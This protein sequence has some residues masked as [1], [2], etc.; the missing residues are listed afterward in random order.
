MRHE[1]ITFEVVKFRRSVVG[2]CPRCNARVVRTRTFEQ[3]VNPFNRNDDGSVKTRPEVL[4]SVKIL[5][6]VWSPD[7]THD[8][9][10]DAA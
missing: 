2:R 9:C 4:A 7:F 1:T 10:R 8:A 3:T 6:E 5:A